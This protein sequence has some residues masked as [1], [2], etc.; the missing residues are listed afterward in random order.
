MRLMI[1]VESLFLSTATSLLF[2]LTNAVGTDLSFA[3]KGIERNPDIVNKLAVTAR[4]ITAITLQNG[5]ANGKIPVENVI[6]EL[7]NIG[8]GELKNV[9]SFG[10]KN[11]D[12]FLNDLKSVQLPDEVAGLTNIEL[13]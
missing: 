9:E 13:G 4:V 11:L 12:K 7:L 2:V 10:N 6:S 5:L 3:S 8:P 1:F